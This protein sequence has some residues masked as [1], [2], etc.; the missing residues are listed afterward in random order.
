MFHPCYST[1]GLQ[2][3]AINAAARQMIKYETTGSN[4]RVGSMSG[5][6]ITK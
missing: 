1:D 6:I 4:R 2:I 5:F 3:M